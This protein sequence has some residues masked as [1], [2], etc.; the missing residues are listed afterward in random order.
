MAISDL[1]SKTFRPRVGGRGGQIKPQRVP[2]F[3]STVIA[4]IQQ[5]IR[6]IAGPRPAGAS[7]RKRH[8]TAGFYGDAP[9]DSSRRCIVKARIVRMAGRGIKAAR[10][11]LSYI[12]RDGVERDGSKGELY[13]DSERTCRRDRLSAE[14]SKEAHQFRFIVSPEDGAELDLREFTRSLMR[15]VESDLGRRLIWGAVNHHDTDNPHVHIVVRGVDLDGHPLRIDREYITQGMRWRAQEVATLELGPRD[16]KQIERQRDREIGQE[17][18]TNLDRDLARLINDTGEVGLREMAPTTEPQER[19]QL[20]ARLATLAELGLAQPVRPG[21]WRLA[22]GWQASLK[23]LGEQGDILKRIHAAV[24]HPGEGAHLRII[25]GTSEIAP[26]EGILRRK[27]LHDEL[28]GDMYAVIEDPHGEG[29]Y[30]RIDAATA[31]RLTEG[32][33][34]RAGVQRDSWAK[35]MDAVLQQVAGESGG[36]YDPQRHLAALAARPLVVGGQRVNPGDVIAANVRRLAR[37]ERHRLVARLPDGRWR[38]PSDLVAQLKVRETTHP[39]FRVHVDQVA[40]GLD[41]QVT[42]RGPTWL[43]SV[44]P[45]AFYGFGAD[46]TRA[47]AQRT[48]HLRDLGIEGSAEKINRALTALERADA[49]KRFAEARGLTFIAEPAAGFRGTLVPC[50][51]AGRD[52]GYVA[53][54]DERGRRFTVVP[55]FGGS[56]LLKGQ[57]VELGLGEDGRFLLKRRELSRG[58]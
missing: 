20:V 48:R 44:E 55:D 52:K 6:R 56:G 25:D 58:R 51:G 21:A 34:V 10:L 19:V 45:R 24:P 46:I 32:T 43:D 18:L 23:E 33:I 27:G 28:R 35:P 36:I 50:L 57:V 41:A 16:V 22:P 40:P 26:V 3:R 29:H 17:R 47:S 15:E 53:I 42:A 8:P 54:L 2:T 7:A 4:R 31:E 12:E 13:G 9:T 49:G 39:R 30:V 38:M 5:R 14:L 1:E 37:L 11:H